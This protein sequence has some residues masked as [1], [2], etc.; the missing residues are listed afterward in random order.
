MGNSTT[1]VKKWIGV[2]CELL[3]EIWGCGSHT[4]WLPHPF[5]VS[6]HPFGP[7]DKL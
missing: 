5:I 6:I 3:A 7:F 4:P 1:H 2:N